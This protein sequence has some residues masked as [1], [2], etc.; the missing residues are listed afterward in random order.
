MNMVDLR[1][2]GQGQDGIRFEARLLQ[3]FGYLTRGVSTVDFPPTDQ[4]LEVLESLK[5]QLAD[6]IRALAGLENGDLAA[7]NRL[8]EE[9]GV[10]AI[11]YG[12]G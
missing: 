3:K 12:G 5:R 8:L 11:G 2:T 4:D 6:H 1:L 9:R 10:P 7:L